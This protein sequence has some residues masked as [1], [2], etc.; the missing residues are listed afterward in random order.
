M[1]SLGPSWSFTGPF[2]K[3]VLGGGG[4]SNGFQHIMLHIGPAMEGW[5]KDMETNSY[6]YNEENL[7][8]LSGSVE[9][10]LT[11]VDFEKLENERND[12]MIDLFKA[13][14]S[15]SALI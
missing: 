11:G 8:M 4:G 13:K 2:M 10:M 9:K 7:K 6:Q 3:D 14:A 12:L 15:S 1:N 5:L